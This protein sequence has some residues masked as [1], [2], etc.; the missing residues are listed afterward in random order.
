MRAEIETRDLVVGRCKSRLRRPNS[1]QTEAVFAT[2]VGTFLGPIPGN[3][4]DDLGVPSTSHQNPESSSAIPLVVWLVAM[5]D[6]SASSELPADWKCSRSLQPFYHLNFSI[7]SPTRFRCAR[8]GLPSEKDR[9]ITDRR[10][11]F[12]RRAPAD[13]TRPQ[14]R[15]H[16]GLEAGTSMVLCRCRRAFQ[17][18]R[19]SA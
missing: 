14:S 5:Q 10:C 15:W 13:T 16:P 9:A 8:R 6:S 18:S 2:T 7:I 17:S 12:R 3:H 11:H 19:L 1:R 4:I